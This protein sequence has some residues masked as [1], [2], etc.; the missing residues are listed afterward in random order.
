M[1]I[2][3]PRTSHRPRPAHLTYPHH[4]PRRPRPYRGSR[5][6]SPPRP[7]PNERAVVSGIQ[8]AP[9]RPDP[10]T[11][12]ARHYDSRGAPRL[13]PCDSMSMRYR[14]PPRCGIGTKRTVMGI[15]PFP[16]QTRSE[17]CVVSIYDERPLLE[18]RTAPKHR[19]ATHIARLPCPTTTSVRPAAN[20]G[21]LVYAL[22]KLGII[23]IG[24]RS[25]SG[26]QTY[27]V[28]KR[29]GPLNINPKAV[30]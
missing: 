27:H 4:T 5:H 9:P 18:G 19:C 17:C 24:R 20:I 22:C 8:T 23:P 10:S 26:E 3:R 28:L 15:L 25:A 21:C 2:V 14:I 1:A 13:V 30:R 7:S 29:G 6:R 11:S 12:A 16:R